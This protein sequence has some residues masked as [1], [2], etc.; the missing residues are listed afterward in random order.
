MGEGI[1]ERIPH[2]SERIKQFKHRTA[3]KKIEFQEKWIIICNKEQQHYRNNNDSKT[4]TTS[5]TR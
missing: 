5:T 1:N 4:L 2:I 3:I